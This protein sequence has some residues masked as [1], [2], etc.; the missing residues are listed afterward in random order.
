MYSEK[1]PKLLAIGVWFNPFLHSYSQ[2]WV[3]GLSMSN[4]FGPDSAAPTLTM[5]SF[6]A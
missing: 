1:L 4:R 3:S 6:T 5:N 2:C